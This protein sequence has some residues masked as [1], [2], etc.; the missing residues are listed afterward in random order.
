MS[1]CRSRSIHLL[2]ATAV[3]G[4]VSVGCP[5]VDQGT[6]EFTVT[7]DFRDYGEIPVGFST[8]ATFTV[9]N[10]SDSTLIGSVEGDGA[11]FPVGGALY[12]VSPGETHQVI[13][14]FAPLETGDFEG[15]L[16]F[17]GGVPLSVPVTGVGIEP[18]E[19]SEGEGEFTLEGSGEGGPDSA[20]FDGQTITLPGGVELEMISLP[21]G[22][23]TMGSTNG[24]SDE[25][26]VHSVTISSGFQLG[27]TEVT[28]AQWTAVMRTTPWSGRSF[29]LDDPN[30][31][32]VWISWNDVQTFIMT[33]NGLT[34]E[35]FRLPTEA[36]WEYACRAG[37]T[38]EYYFGDSSANLSDYAWYEQNAHSVHEQFAHIVGQ[39]LPNAFGLY[40]MH[41]N[42]W[43][44]CEDWYDSGY[45][46]S[47]PSSDPPGPTSGSIRVQRGGSWIISATFCRSANRYR[48]YP[49]CADNII[50][51]R[52][53]R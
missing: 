37:S 42:V 49:S 17:S 28:K 8:D 11:F 22:T 46:D 51:L 30:S 5:T 45:Y 32:A 18:S 41:G 26:P 47:S 24:H 14:R 13:V 6:I 15:I 39:L 36:E 29:V 2:V 27:Q 1:S 4:T 3:L 10:P 20:N 43:E 33:L 38:T 16:F 19:D 48:D 40:D 35:T 52:L 25:T 23:F 12:T 50:G 7:P 21:S 34:G 53:A 44:W 31:P 9:F